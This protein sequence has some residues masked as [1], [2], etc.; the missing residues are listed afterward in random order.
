MVK[1]L[2]YCGISAKI[3]KDISETVSQVLC[4]LFNESFSK[5][6]F[7]DYMKLAM[8]IPIY[9]RKSKLKVSSYRPVSVLR[10]LSKILEKMYG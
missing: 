9:K 3:L 1:M 2:W 7:P 4:D 10:I 6:I 8:I 5:G